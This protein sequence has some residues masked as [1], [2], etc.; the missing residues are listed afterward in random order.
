[1]TDKN[2]PIG[3]TLRK[4]RA[5]KGYTQKQISDATMARS[6]YTKFE[7]GVITPTLAKY[8]AIL[9]HMD[10]THEEF[11]YISNDYAMDQK[12][13]IQQLFQQLEWQF[14]ITVA[15]EIV[16]RGEE[17]LKERYDQLTQDT[18]N[19]SLGYKA[20]F[21]EQ[22]LEKARSYAGLVWE[23][24][25]KLD[26]YYLAEL[27]LLNSILYL[28]DS[29][30]AVLLTN[31]ALSDLERYKVHEEAEAL[32]L[33]FLLHVTNRLMLDERYAEA[34]PFIE[35]MEAC[36]NTK[37]PLSW[38]IALIRKAVCL[39]KSGGEPEP[40][41]VEKGIRVFESLEQ[42]ELAELAKR[43]PETFW[44]VYVVEK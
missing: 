28:F 20:L 6:T 7:K 32:Q 40:E 22:D 33:S 21:E 24:L 31:R 26:K 8:L 5:N 36:D 43:N 12:G 27:H 4:I 25:E 34:L 18:V 42:T 11:I 39:E 2:F 41:L 44:N 13:Q 19:A 10:M 37:H 23:R 35:Q 9:D 15:N 16:E 30:T 17:L 3:A 1:M 29:V 38:A 14:D